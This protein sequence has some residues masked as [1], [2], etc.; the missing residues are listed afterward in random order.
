MVRDQVKVE[1]A[2]R[3]RIILVVEEQQLDA[4]GGA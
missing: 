1:D 3:Q 2:G 4:I